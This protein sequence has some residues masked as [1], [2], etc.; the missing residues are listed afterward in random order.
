MPKLATHTLP[1][2]LQVCVQCGTSTTCLWRRDSRLSGSG[3]ICNACGC[4]RR[5]R[6]L[7]RVHTEEQQLQRLQELRRFLATAAQA[8]P[9][10]LPPGCAPAGASAAAPLCPVEPQGWQAHT[11]R[12]QAGVSDMLPPTPL[13]PAPGM[14]AAEQYS[15]MQQLRQVVAAAGDQR[16]SSVVPTAS[17]PPQ[18]SPM[19]TAQ[20]R[21][22]VS[23]GQAGALPS[24][25]QQPLAAAA[26]PPGTLCQPAARSQPQPAPTY[27]AYLPPGTHAPG[28]M[29][30][31]AIQP[32]G[33]AAAGVGPG[34]YAAAAKSGGPTR[35]LQAP[36]PAFIP[37]RVTPPAAFAPHTA[38]P[39]ASFAPHSSGPPAAFAPHTAG[40]PTAFAPH[41][42]GAPSAF[43]PHT[44]APPTSAPLASES[45]APRPRPNT[46]HPA[47]SLTPFPSLD[48]FSDLSQP[49]LLNA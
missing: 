4:Q 41:S 16:S 33:S 9:Q 27:V 35:L 47:M 10:Q 42:S 7:K 21:P 30:V 23:P 3:Y 37:A 32:P 34:C 19:S 13:A 1:L 26:Q 5:R 25:P 12:Q 28:P 48:I 49:L 22:W 38:G 6:R 39:P 36:P 17:Q 46:P 31:M 8:A 24:W 43:A 11:Q 29:W 14:P 18:P 45:P 2:S 20:T 44:A 40:P 15:R